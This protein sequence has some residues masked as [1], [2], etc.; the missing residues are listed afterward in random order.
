VCMWRKTKNA[1]ANTFGPLSL[2]ADCISEVECDCCTM[3]IAFGVQTVTCANKH[4]M[5]IS[6]M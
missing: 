2:D 1:N 4:N 6:T 3:E 5:N